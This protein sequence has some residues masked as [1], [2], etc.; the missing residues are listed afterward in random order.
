MNGPTDNAEAKRTRRGRIGRW[1]VG[2]LLLVVLLPAAAVLVFIVRFNPNAYSPAIIQAVDRATG[3]QLTLGQPIT[4]HYGLDPT[5]EAT[6][7]KLSNPPGYPDASLVTLRALRARIALLP[8]LSHRI[9]VLDLTLVGPD[10][11]L[12]RT[13]AGG[14]DF[15]LSHPAPAPAPPAANGN[16]TH[17]Q[18]YRVA[19]RDVEIEQGS[20]TL[21]GLGGRDPLVVGISQATGTA[22]SLTDPLHLSASATIAHTPFEI[23][24]TVGPIARLSGIGSGDW[25]IDLTLKLGNATGQVHGFLAHPRRGR[26]YDVTVSATIPALASV[27]ALLPPALLGGWQVPPLQ[28]LSAHA[29]IVDQH[30]AVPAIDDFQLSVGASDLAAVRPDLKLAGFQASMASLDQPIQLSGDGTL[31]DQR[32]ELQGDFGAPQALLPAAWLP[33]SMPPQTNYPVAFTAQLGSAKLDVRGAIATPEKLAGTALAVAASIPD[34]SKLDGAAGTAMPGWRNIKLNTAVIDPGG[35]GLKTAIGL[36]DLSLTMD[37]AALSGVADLYFGARP[38]FDAT[39]KASE[40]ELDP[41]LAAMPKPAPETGASP[42][43]GLPAQNSQPSL[44]AQALPLALLRRANAD[45]ELSADTLVWHQATYAALQ[46]HAVLDGGVL[47][48]SPVHA[49]LPGGSVDA[50]ASLDARADPAAE[51]LDLVAPAL[52]IGPLLQAFGITGA[53]EGTGQLQIHIRGTGDRLQDIE[54]NL[55]GQLGLA[56]VNGTVE[57][58]VLSELFSAV[59]SAV[60]LPSDFGAD[61]GPVAVRCAALRVDAEHGLGTVRALTLDSSRLLVQG[62]GTVDLADN[63]LDLVLR[64]EMQVADTQVG[65]PVQLNG[66]IAGPKISLA[67]S[68]ALQAA[69]KDAAGLTISAAQEALGKSSVLGKAAA[70][71]GLAPQTDV[72]PAALAL[73]RLGQPGPAAPPPQIEKSASPASIGQPKSLLKALLGQ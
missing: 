47:K 28:N 42:P 26:G 69:A 51:T 25:P 46:G 40:I 29:R 18:P 37:H 24:G 9:E 5:L 11:A 38:R 3:R 65:V 70:M 16:P 20:V 45:V 61:Q 12:E 32:F 36:D 64:P 41:L 31:G 48:L 60:G 55:S 1:A 57:G 43:P 15:E 56:M 52:S 66:P 8:L 54:S 2:L 35:L 71:L 58:R 59:L 19:I 23:S 49:Q 63:T 30:A 62:G 13:Q 68:Q 73:A 34:L 10:V 72:C 44:G 33:A 4:L 7:L 17:R 22:D 39:L 6:D 50:S 14:W 53:A 67:P 27:L 21:K